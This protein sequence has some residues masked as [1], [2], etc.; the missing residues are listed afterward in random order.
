[1]A[2][3]KLQRFRDIILRAYEAGYD[4][5]LEMKEQYAEDAL[6]EVVKEMQSKDAGEWR[7]YTVEELKKKECGVLFEHVRL[8]RGWV[9]GD[10][11]GRRMAFDSGQQL[12]FQDNGPPWTEPMRELGRV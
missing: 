10:G 11:E 3:L 1:M 12:F 6:A 8:G 2:A 4:G 7:L 5:C 9:E